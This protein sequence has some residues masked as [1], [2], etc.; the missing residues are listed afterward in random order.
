MLDSMYN[1]YLLDREHFQ[2]EKSIN[3]TKSHEAWHRYGKGL[4]ISTDGFLNIALTKSSKTIVLQ[5][6]EQIQKKSVLNWHKADVFIS[7]FSDDGSMLA[8]GG[9]DGKTVVYSM[10]SCNMLFS[11][12]PRPDY[13][14]NIS[15]S[16][17]SRFL[18]SSSFDGSNV[19][20][21][22]ERS[23]EC[24]EF[25]TD[26]II[27][28]AH[29]FDENFRIFY[30]CKD[31]ST[32]VYNVEE[33]KQEKH[34]KYSETWYTCLAVLPNGRY[35]VVGGKDEFIRIVRMVDNALM[36]AIKIEHVGIS[37]MIFLDDLLLV[38][39]I[40]GV[41]EVID[42]KR[43]ADEIDIHLKVN[44]FQKAREVTEKNI[45]L[46]VY[47]QYT[48]KMAESWKDV[49]QVAIDLLAKNDID[50]AMANVGPFIEDPA[51][52]EEFS[53]YMAQRQHVAEFMDALEVKDFVKAYQLSREHD[54]ILQLSVY[55][56]LEAYWN[57]VFEASKRLLSANPQLNL[58]KAK[59]LLK[60]FMQVRTKKD[61]ITTLL[62][63]SD[64]YIAADQ[65]LKER[66]FA[67]YFRLTEKFTF[68]KETEQYRKTLML[69]EQLLEKASVLENKREFSKALEAVKIL[70]TLVPFKITAIERAKLIEKKMSFI[71]AINKKELITAYD[72]VQ[73]NS[74]LKSMPEFVKLTQDFKA[75]SEKAYSLAF[76]GRPRDVMSVLTDYLSIKYWEEKVASIMQVAYLNEIKKMAT[77]MQKEQ[78][79]W[80][81]TFEEFIERFGKNDELQK[82]TEITQLIG[83]LNS[84]S[85]DGDPAGYKNVS[86]LT[87]VLAMKSS[88]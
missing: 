50:T 27:E 55:E 87:S 33:N 11:L 63:N 82:I 72:I 79:D 34:E 88:E 2:F 43:F 26:A 66:K 5:L 32:G 17:D 77:S 28:D 6:G 86:Y 75:L 84:I 37:R 85:D 38:G 67:D 73:Q 22:L 61:I 57:K 71:D 36:F 8:T 35:A 3:I 40:D 30:I 53:F 76:A 24:L 62:S 51:R 21:D 31:G 1:M 25:E 12:F 7:V 83:I 18:I 78:V 60:P 46:R 58:Q 4:S 48:D 20:M 47:D 49:L 44:D 15:F 56:E 14:S 68:L 39:Y 45:F 23:T 80:K 52:K 81:R 29:F 19:V 65:A 10:P 64:K 42:T 54:E 41:I 16:S 69:G 13:I 74:N 59:E 9:E 70:A